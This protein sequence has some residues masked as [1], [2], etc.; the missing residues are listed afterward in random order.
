MATTISI[1]NSLMRQVNHWLTAASK[2]SVVEHLASPQ[3]W[4]GIDHE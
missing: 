3:A 4:Q 1:Y 2:L